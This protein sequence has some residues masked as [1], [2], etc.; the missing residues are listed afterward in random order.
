MQMY[1][2]QF[3]RQEGPLG[4][5]QAKFQ[6]SAE[7]LSFLEAL[8]NPIPCLFQ[9]QRP[10]T[11][12]G[13]WPAMS[14]LTSV[15]ISPSDHSQEKSFAFRNSYHNFGLIWITRDNLQLRFLNLI[16]LR[17][18]SCH[19]FIGH[20]TYSQVTVIQGSHD[21]VYHIGQIIFGVIT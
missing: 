12:V 13:L 20:K 19:I 8:G 9:L 14:H 4:S 15:I 18:P 10:P 21:S 6:V 5:H 1:D 17:S 11:F 3:C 7:W 2:L 16:Y